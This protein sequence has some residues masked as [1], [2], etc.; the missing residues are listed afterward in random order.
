MHGPGT[1]FVRE[2]GLPR[3]HAT[4]ALLWNAMIVTAMKAKK[5]GETRLTGASPDVLSLA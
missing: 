4:D 3:R 5:A 1:V 2:Q